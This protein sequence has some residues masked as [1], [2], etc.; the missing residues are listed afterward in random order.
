MAYGHT[1]V[2]LP[3]VALLAA[4]IFSSASLLSSS[5]DIIGLVGG[6]AILGFAGYQVLTLTGMKA[7]HMPGFSAS[8]GPFIAGIALS[9]LNQFFII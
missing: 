6:L 1:A 9:A 8:R 3:F 2:E 5:L 4:G 7:I